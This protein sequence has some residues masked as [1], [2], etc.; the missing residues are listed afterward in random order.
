MHGFSEDFRNGRISRI[1]NGNIYFFSH[2]LALYRNQFIPFKMIHGSICVVNRNSFTPDY[3]D[4]I[5]LNQSQREP[6]VFLLN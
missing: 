6:Q 4:K 1:W 2:Q 5:Q 3:L